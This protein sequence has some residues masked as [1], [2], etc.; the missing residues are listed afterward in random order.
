M[1]RG[2]ALLSA[3]AL[4]G[5]VAAPAYAT[6]VTVVMTGT[7]D[8]VDD[9]ADVLDDSAE[10]GDSFTATLVYDDSV[11]DL[12]PSDEF[13]A[14]F[15]EGVPWDLTIVAG[16]FTFAAGSG[17][18]DVGIGVWNNNP[19]GEDLILLNG[20]NYVGSGPFPVGVATGATAYA[21]PSLTD[22]SGTALGSDSLVGLNWNLADYDDAFFYLFVEI[23]GE[24]PMQ[25]VE[26]QGTITSIEVLPEPAALLTMVVAVAG[27]I[28]RRRV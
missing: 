27:L 14:Y 11:S 23:T 24:G 6:S 4:A 5:F 19:D 15:T 10:A 12:D 8:A 25:F 28:G 18:F 2:R 17:T 26:F 16:N 9:S 13:G 7:W 22:L 3:L 20:E 21:A 1:R